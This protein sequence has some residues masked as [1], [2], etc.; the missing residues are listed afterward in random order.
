MDVGTWRG[1]NLLF[2]RIFSLMWGYAVSLLEKF[3]LVQVLFRKIV[4]FK[5]LN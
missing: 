2:L 5:I 3:L 1:G 4:I